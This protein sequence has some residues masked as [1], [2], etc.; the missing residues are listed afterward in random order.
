M[1][2]PSCKCGC[3]E[4]LPEKSTR[5]FKRNHDPERKPHT[6]SGLNEW[7][8]A[9]MLRVANQSTPIEYPEI[10]EPDNEDYPHWTFDSASEATVNDPDPAY[11][12]KPE[13]T[14]PVLKLTGQQKKDIEAKL[15]FWLELGSTMLAPLDPYCIPVMQEHTPNIAKKLLPI[16][17][18][19]PEMVE[20]FSKAGNFALWADLAMACW[21]VITV[22]IAHHLMKTV[23]HDREQQ[24]QIYMPNVDAYSTDIPYNAAY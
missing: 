12:D 5:D 18:Q 15:V 17:T 3:G 6:A 8:R 2:G 11:Q 16:I 14:K 13:V 20:W 4:F 24:Q 22:I 10:D 7:K 21:P 19:S 1:T 23:G 9:E